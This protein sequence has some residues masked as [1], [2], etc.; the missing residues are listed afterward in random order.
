M[1][2]WN[3]VKLDG[4]ENEIQPRVVVS[5]LEMCMDNCLAMAECVAFHFYEPYHKDPDKKSKIGCL[6]FSTTQLSPSHFRD[7]DDQ[8]FDDVTG[9]KCGHEFE[10]K[11]LTVGISDELYPEKVGK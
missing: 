8:T 11:T 7:Y 2:I 3:S 9:V 4:W 10:Y 5:N 6:L 1:Q